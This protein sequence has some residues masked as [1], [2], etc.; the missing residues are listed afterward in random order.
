MQEDLVQFP[1]LT[2]RGLVSVCNSSPR[3]PDTFL[4]SH[5]APGT[6]VVHGHPCRQ[7]THTQAQRKERLKGTIHHSRPASSPARTRMSFVHRTSCCYITCPWGPVPTETLAKQT[8]SSKSLLL[9][10]EKGI[11]GPGRPS[12]NSFPSFLSDIL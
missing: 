4:W 3:G 9:H 11:G 10:S 1:A 12:L 2:G 7:D 6:Q 8:T 5:P